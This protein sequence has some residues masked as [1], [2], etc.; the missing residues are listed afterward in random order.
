[1]CADLVWSK[2]SRRVVLSAVLALVLAAGGSARGEE[3]MTTDEVA[4]E[5]AELTPKVTPFTLAYDKQTKSI[6]FNEVIESSDKSLKGRIGELRARLDRMDPKR[7][8]YEGG[9]P[10][11]TLMMQGKPIGGVV[12]FHC[13]ENARCVSRGFNDSSSPSSVVETDEPGF[14][15][16]IFAD[17]ATFNQIRRFGTLI[18]HLIVV[19]TP[20]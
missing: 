20:E 18:Q 12:R 14:L 1:M 19:S 2:L 10:Q 11:M 3:P 6:I 13:R 8:N 5:L 15:I 16:D 7:M 4:A 17:T 9:N